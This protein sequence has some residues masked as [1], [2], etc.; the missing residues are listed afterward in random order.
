MNLH[1]HFVKQLAEEKQKYERVL[2][3]NSIAT[4]A[5]HT[6]DF[7]NALYRVRINS[8]WSDKGEADGLVQAT[9]TLERVTDMAVADYL[10][11]NKRS[12]VQGRVS[13]DVFIGNLWYAVPTFALPSIRD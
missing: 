1:E 11:K 2:Y 7:Q 9:G 6:T 5:L 4:T 13:A 8:H 10:Q 12:D 3:D